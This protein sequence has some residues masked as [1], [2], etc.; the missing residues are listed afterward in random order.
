[1]SKLSVE[2]MRRRTI[3]SDHMITTFENR[4]FQTSS[5]RITGQLRE[6]KRHNHRDRAGVSRQGDPVSR[7]LRVI[8]LTDVID[9]YSVLEERRSR[10]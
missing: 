4:A 6:S 1:M 5:M 3:N 10:M 2:N 7:M 9:T 8:S